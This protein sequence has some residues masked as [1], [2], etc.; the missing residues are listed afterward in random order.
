MPRDP[1]R[2]F[3]VDDE[4]WARWQAAAGHAGVSVSEWL[5]QAADQFERVGRVSVPGEIPIELRQLGRPSEDE[6]AAL[7][8]RAAGAKV[9]KG[10]LPK[11]ERKKKR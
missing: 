2:N 7:A 3:R 6:V 9:F 11:P 10:P 1:L 8:S 5:R 4:T